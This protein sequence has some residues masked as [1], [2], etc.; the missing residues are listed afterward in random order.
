MRPAIPDRTTENRGVPGSS[1]GLAISRAEILHGCGIFDS[2]VQ[3]RLE[4]PVP[5]VEIVVS[6]V[7]VR[8]A[9]IGSAAGFR[10]RRAPALQRSFRVPS[11]SPL[12]FAAFCLSLIESWRPGGGRPASPAAVDGRSAAS[13]RP[14][15][16][17]IFVSLVGVV[18]LDVEIR[19]TSATSTVPVP[20]GFMVWMSKF[21]LAAL[22][23][24]IRPFAPGN[25]AK[26]GTGVAANPDRDADEDTRA[27][28]KR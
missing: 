15:R 12:L 1:P 4:L 25:V 14:A 10:V 24:A 6:S 16:N 2:V 23:K 21:P 13:A 26:A 17:A 27:S 3:R 20:S 19:E 8:D 5:R 28:A 7:R 11:R 22:A 9:Q 18:G